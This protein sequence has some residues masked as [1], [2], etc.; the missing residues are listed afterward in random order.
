MVNTKALRVLCLCAIGFVTFPVVAAQDILLEAELE[1]EQVYVQAQARY[2]LRFYHAVDVRDLV[3]HAPSTRVADLRPLGDTRMY[4]RMRDGRRY[5]VHER[6]FAVLPFASGAL[7]LSGAYATGRVPASISRSADGR[8][9]LRV[10]APPRTLTVLPAPIVDG[11]WLPAQSLTLSES[12]ATTG[13]GTGATKKRTIRVEATGVN[14]AQLPELQLFAPGI[15]VQVLPARL[16]NRVAADELIAV[17]EQ[18]FLLTPERAGI[19]SLPEVQLPWWTPDGTP[20]IATLPASALQGLADA[21]HGAAHSAAHAAPLASDSKAEPH[22]AFS[23]RPLLWLTVAA[24]LGVTVRAFRPHRHVRLMRACLLGDTRAVCTGLLAWAADTW[25]HAPPR[26]LGALA[27]RLQDARAR[28]SLAQLD[29]SLYG[30]DEGK[31]D[32]AALRR[33]VVRVMRSGRHKQYDLPESRRTTDG[34][35]FIEKTGWK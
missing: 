6:S 35:Q 33:T 34:N 9:A 19:I 26:T 23:S 8:Q 18:S 21:V 4:E 29:R 27:G 7:E 17:R 25:R 2:R 15:T 22:P 24:V 14:A 16:G 5:R 32:R 12:W 28:E 10:D 3:L 31:I 30:A 13:A 11:D 1:P 20:K